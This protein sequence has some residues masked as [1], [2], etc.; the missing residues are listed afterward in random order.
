MPE[1]IPPPASLLRQVA[2]SQTVKI[3]SPTADPSGWQELGP[4]DIFGKLSNGTAAKLEC[5]VCI[6]ILCYEVMLIVLF[7]QLFLA[8]PV[9]Y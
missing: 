4:A 3:P 8:I 6:Y 1:I 9:S 2:Y 7:R 5:K